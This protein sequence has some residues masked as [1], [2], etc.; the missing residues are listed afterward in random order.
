MCNTLVPK[1]QQNRTIRVSLFCKLT[2]FIF[3]YRHRWPSYLDG[4]GFWPF[5]SLWDPILYKC[6]KSGANVSICSRN[7]HRKR[8]S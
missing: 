2:I 4:G 5:C 6:A 8:N 1:F 7:I 3:Q